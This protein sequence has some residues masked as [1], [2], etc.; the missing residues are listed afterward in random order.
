MARRRY[1]SDEVRRKQPRHVKVHTSMVGHPRYGHVYQDLELRGMW[2]GVLI[3]AFD[4]FAAK[5]DDQVW[6]SSKD[7]LAIT[8]RDQARAAWIVLHRLF[9]A[10]DWRVAWLTKG[11]L[12]AGSVDLAEELRRPCAA[13]PQEL[14]SIR[15]A[16]VEVRN[17]AK[18]QGLDSAL[19][20]PPNAE[21][22]VPIPLRAEAVASR[23]P[24]APASAAPRAPSEEEERDVPGWVRARRAARHR[25]RRGGGERPGE[26]E[27]TEL[28]SSLSEAEIADEL[29][30]L[31]QAARESKRSEAKVRRADALR[32][33]KR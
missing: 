16:L 31:D 22:Q 33:E 3:A 2:L 1:Q 30:L 26:A 20:T 11:L 23:A 13:S 14:R 8:G 19:H 17:F 32:H 9:V 24:H 15:G 21:Y 10:M 25:L 29:E 6:L 28:A 4:H 12:S 7:A 27:V 18:K 5:R